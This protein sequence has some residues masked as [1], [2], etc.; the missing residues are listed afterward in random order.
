MERGSGKLGAG[1]GL[2]AKTIHCTPSRSF[3]RWLT[4]TPSPPPF[5][6]V[7]PWASQ[8]SAPH[9][10]SSNSPSPPYVLLCRFWSVLWAGSLSFVL[11][12]S[13]LL[14]YWNAVF[15]PLPTALN[16]YC[17]AKK[18]PLFSFIYTQILLCSIYLHFD[19]ITMRLR[20]LPTLLAI[21]PLILTILSFIFTVLSTTSKQWAYQDF[22][23]EDGV[24]VSL[25]QQIT[26]LWTIYRSP[27][28]TCGR[29]A[30][31]TGTLSPLPF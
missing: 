10:A 5:F 2:S 3:P 12:T 8:R 28:W 17:L 7:Q 15:S 25:D 18:P 29:G 22:Y 11:Q 13:F 16:S 27:F 31:A 4:T 23:A 30:N 6:L 19:S 9:P 14:C 24:V 20:L 21:V 1:A 26:P